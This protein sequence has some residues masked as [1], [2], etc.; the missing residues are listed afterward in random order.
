MEALLQA[1]QHAHAQVYPHQA[2]LLAAHAAASACRE[3]LRSS[4]QAL[5]LVADSRDAFA[6]YRVGEELGLLWDFSA[7]EVTRRLSHQLDCAAALNARP[8][9]GSVACAS[10]G[11]AELRAGA[12]L[13][14]A[15][16]W[17]TMLSG[18][19]LSDCADVFD[20]A[21]EVVDF[22]LRGG[23]LMEVTAV[24]AH[25]AALRTL[26]SGLRALVDAI[27]DACVARQACS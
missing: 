13:E 2:K 8:L 25:G 16:V 26:A 11:L 23:I 19:D 7:P 3:T 15:A 18:A 20:A 14:Q 5:R 12:L 27:T 17:L 4:A 6:Y 10:K 9:F 1:G 21:A 22:Q 24:C